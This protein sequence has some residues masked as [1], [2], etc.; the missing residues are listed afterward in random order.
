MQD[1]VIGEH[2]LDEL[3]AGIGAK[4]DH[5]PFAVGV[6][7]RHHR[8][9]GAAFV[10]RPEDVNLWMGRENVPGLLKRHFRQPS[11]LLGDE[12]HAR[13]LPHHLDEPVAARVALLGEL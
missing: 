11:V 6:F 7:D 13:Q 3:P 4:D 9:N 8:P 12:F 10:G 5:L 2:E 1:A